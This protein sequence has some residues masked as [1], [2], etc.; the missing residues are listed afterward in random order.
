[1]N[2]IVRIRFA[3]MSISAL[4]CG[5]AGTQPTVQISTGPT[6]QEIYEAHFSG[7]STKKIS[8]L[9]MG[10]SDPP[11]C[12]PKG[13]PGHSRIQN[14]TLHMYVYPHLHPQENVPVSGYYVSF[15]M[16]ERVEYTSESETTEFCGP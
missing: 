7:Q 9:E 5:C 13:S 3:I 16:Y 6:V 2:K 8:N 4:F 10:K 12:K 14:P 1:M 15:P 11:V